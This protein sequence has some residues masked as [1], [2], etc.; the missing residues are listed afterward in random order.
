[1]ICGLH[2][3]RVG[4]Q[5]AAQDYPF[6]SLLMAAMRKADNVNLAKLQEA[7]PEVYA[8]L[9]A[10]YNAPGGYLPDEQSPQ[11]VRRR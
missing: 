4:Q 7:Y 9:S 6:Y 11:G 3:Y 8:E 5:I 1:M 10:R 2:A